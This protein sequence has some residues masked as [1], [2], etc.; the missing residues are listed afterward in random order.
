MK[1]RIPVPAN[2]KQEQ[3]IEELLLW[4]IDAEL[5][6][7]FYTWHYERVNW[8]IERQWAVWSIDPKD[9]FIFALKWGGHGYKQKKEK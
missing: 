9:Y 2:K 1:V 3:H 5:E 8:R 6:F 7:D 4:G